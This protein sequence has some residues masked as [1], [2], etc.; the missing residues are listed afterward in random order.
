MKLSQK[1]AEIRRFCEAH[2]DPARV[3]KYARYFVEGYDAYGLEQKLAE[4]QRDRWLE[5]WETQLGLEGFLRLGSLLVQSGKYEEA[6]FAIWFAAA[7]RPRFVAETLPKLGDWLEAGGIRNWAHT[8]VFCGDVLSHFLTGGLV[9]PG[10]FSSWRN[11]PSKWKR[12]AVPVTLLSALRAGIP[13][14]TLLEFIAPMMLDLER[15]V[16]QGLGWFLREAWKR[17]RERTEESLLAWKDTCGRTII[18]YAT[19]KMSPADRARFKRQKTAR[20]QKATSAG[21]RRSRQGLQ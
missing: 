2:A 9:G 7:H 11:A 1:V 6:S 3:Q 21:H 4:T 19:E 13:I 8:D 15:V 12:R 10:A 20:P 16:Q 14:G 5:A 17:D 18:Q